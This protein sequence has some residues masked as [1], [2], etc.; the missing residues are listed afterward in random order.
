[1]NH[2]IRLAAVVTLALLVPVV[3]ARASEKIATDTG[4]KCTACH[5]KPGSKLLTDRGKYF[6]VMHS[7]EGYDQLQSSFGR[8]TSCHVRKPGS[9]KLT[10]RGQQL[11]ANAKDMTELREWI[12]AG[13]PAPDK[14]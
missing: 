11:Q 8:C 3:S 7:V 2:R 9:K 13:H 4:Q 10:K 1:M 12:R 5:D 14:K 6:E